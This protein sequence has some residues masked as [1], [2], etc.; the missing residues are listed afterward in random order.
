MSSHVFYVFVV[1]CAMH[2][3]IFFIDSPFE[4]DCIYVYIYSF[5]S[6]TCPCN[7][8]GYGATSNRL[9]FSLCI[10]TFCS[11]THFVHTKGL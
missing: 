4:I 2:L 3:Y 11:Y 1:T 6:G 5:Q 7:I 9:S 8:L 10:H